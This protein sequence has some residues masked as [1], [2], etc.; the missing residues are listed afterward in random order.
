MGSVLALD[1]FKI[2]FGLPTESGGFASTKN[3][4]VASN[5]VSLLTAGCF[6]GAIAAAFVNDRFG[7]RFSLMFFVTVFLI[8]AAIQTGAHHSIGQIYGGRV[9]AGLGIGGMSSITPVFVSENCPPS[10]R[11]R[12]AGLFQEFLVIGSTFAY[13]LDYGV[14]LH[15]PQGTKQWRTPVAIQIIPGALMLIGL[16]FLKESPRWLMKKQRSDD[17]LASLSYIRNLPADDPEVQKELAEIRAAIEEELN[18]TEGVTWKECLQKGNRIRFFLAF[19]IMLCQQFSGTNSIGYYAPQIFETVGV[20]STNSSLFATGVYGTVKVVA[21]GI[22]LLIG[23]DKWGRRNSLIGGAAW[24]ASM[25]FIIGAVLATNPPNPDSD[26][27]SSP[28][29]A[30]VAM[31]YLYVIGYSFSWGPTPWVY[32][33]EVSNMASSCSQ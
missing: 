20:S 14:S 25:M 21:T 4:K 29:I 13:W 30:M 19:F 23:I 2:D 32:V 11:G 31:I 17:A 24:M 28:S 12:V 27:V 5:V 15:I 22:F 18:L 16:F 26:K 7:R 1:S 6:F 10:T 33:S 3:S 9:I 8:G